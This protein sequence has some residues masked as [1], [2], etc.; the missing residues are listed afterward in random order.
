MLGG[1][2]SAT[3]ILVGRS[4][5]A[6]ARRRARSSLAIV[7]SLA[8]AMAACGAAQRDDRA[9]RVPAAARRAATRAADHG[10]RDVV[11]PPGRRAS[12]WKGA[13][14]HCGAERPAARSG[15][16]DRRRRCYTW[17][18]LIVVI[19]TVPVLLALI[20]LVQRTRQGKA[21]RATAQDR[22]A[23]AMMGIDVNRTISFTFLLAGALAGAGRPR[24][25]ALLRRRSA[26][27]PA[28]SS[29]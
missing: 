13:G 8:V 9:R 25:R 10:D 12:R 2:F 26:T 21:M 29:G 18:K 22:D 4:I 14:L 24:L 1:M 28:S 11:H 17:E 23:A 19:I 20:W 16:L 15:L 6:N 3:M 7:A 5:S 27:T